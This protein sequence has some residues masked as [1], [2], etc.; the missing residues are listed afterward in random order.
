[1][2]K[3][4]ESREPRKPIDTTASRP[5]PT[6]MLPPQLQAMVKSVA[7]VYHV[8]DVMPAMIALSMVSAMVGKGLRIVSAQGRRTMGNLYFLGS[9]ASGTGK[10]TILRIMREPLDA[11]QALLG[12]YGCHLEMSRLAI[13]PPLP[14]EASE[15]GSEGFEGSGG[16][17]DTMPKSEE[18]LVMKSC[19][20]NDQLEEGGDPRLIC[21]EVTGPALAKLLLENNQVILNATAEAGNLLDESAKVSSPLGQ[22]LLKGYSGD[23]VEIDRMTRKPVVMEEPCITACWFC[24]PHR[25]DKFLNNARLLEDGLL[26]RFLVAH[27]EASMPRMTDSDESVPAEVSDAYRALIEKLFVLYGR[28]SKFEWEARASLE[29][30]KVLRDY[31][32]QG[33]E[34]WQS[35]GG[36]LQSC[37]ARWTEQAW[38]LTL[39]LHAALHGAEAHL[40][41][42][43]QG[44]AESAVVLHQWFADQQIQIIEGAAVEVKSIRLG[45]LCDLLRDTP[46]QEMTLR[47]LQNSHGFSNEEVRSLLQAAP[48]QLCI[49]KRKNSAGGR[50]SD[51]VSLLHPDL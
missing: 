50:P 4:S 35:D 42:V 9:A 47:N 12:E 6:E 46:D 5:F 37:I 36:P 18:E 44:T 11:I 25:L 33:V 30:Q 41:E 19:D 51:V 34:R 3:N 16:G 40:V 14:K 20:A 24:Q 49:V 45:K 48:L 27:S 28:N 23:H 32:N 1:M 17:V 22:L 26:A 15:Q 10:S 8:P 2:K 43:D 39:V 29:A 21:S 31:H 38:K 7:H 13:K